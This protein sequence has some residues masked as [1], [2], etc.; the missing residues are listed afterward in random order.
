MQPAGMTMT[1]TVVNPQGNKLM[2]KEIAA[3]SYGIASADFPLDSQAPSGDYTITAEMGPT[4]QLAQRRGQAIQP[5]P[6]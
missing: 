2:R 1:L 3:S 4:V 5:A 6:L